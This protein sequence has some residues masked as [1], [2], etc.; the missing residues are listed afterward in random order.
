[1]WADKSGN[2]WIFGGSLEA[3]KQYG[4]DLWEYVL[5]RNVSEFP[6][7][8]M[9]T[10]SVAA[11]TYTSVQSVAISD[12]TIG[13]TIYYTMDGTAP[14][15]QS[16]AYSAPISVSMSETIEAIA[17]ASGFNI[18][19][20]AKAPYTIN[21][22][23]PDFSFSPSSTSLTVAYGGS[24]SLDLTVS[25]ENGFSDTVGFSCEGLPAGATCT[26]SPSGVRP[27]GTN[28]AKT[29]LTI[30]TTKLSANADERSSKPLVSLAALL[31]AVALR[32]R[33]SLYL[34]APLILLSISVI[35][36]ASCGGGTSSGSGQPGPSSTTVKIQATSGKLVKSLNIT[37]TEE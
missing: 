4:N 30:T 7:A 6:P 27:D 1:M 16:T 23:L 28:P 34:L 2:L 3:V 35:S 21:L 33:R 20:V 13:A 10:F 11:G 24:G 25:P 18:S 9:P 19:A 36:L 26:F 29:T 14:T 22:P 31:C 8:A 15:T 37:L 12:S 5:P 32:R 17:V